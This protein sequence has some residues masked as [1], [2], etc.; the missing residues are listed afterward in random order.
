MKLLI[1]WIGSLA[2]SV[3][4][5]I[6]VF[7]FILRPCTVRGGLSCHWTSCIHGRLLQ[8]WV[9]VCRKVWCGVNYC[10]CK[11]DEIITSKLCYNKDT[12]NTTPFC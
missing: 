3:L 11:R 1:L 7:Q 8:Y 12:T 10:L 5:T 6:L 4:S 9:C 2:A